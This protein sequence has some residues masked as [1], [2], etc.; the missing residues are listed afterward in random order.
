MKKNRRETDLFPPLATYLE[1][2]G[3]IV[4]A[5][6][7]GTDIA[8]RKDDELLLIEMKLQF[9]LE[10]VLQAVKKQG[11]ADN[12][13]VAIPVSGK[14]RYPPRWSSIRE[15]MSRL[16]IG[17]FFVRFYSSRQ[18]VVEK[19]VAASDPRF[20]GKLRKQK[21][22]QEEIIREIDGRPGNFNV[23]GSTRKKL[24][25]A[26]LVKVIRI[27]DLLKG[28][29]KGLSI[30]ELKELGAPENCGSI[31]RNDFNN[32]FFKPARGIYTLNPEGK[33]SLRSYADIIKLLKNKKTPKSSG[34]LK[35]AI[36]LKNKE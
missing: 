27:A 35:T 36:E 18:P 4:H 2:E 21:K 9:N 19:V 25:T 5:E 29:P 7:K 28:K 8:A 11:A 10:V 32:W 34:L 3:Y 16:G 13:Y 33:K 23:G 31:L 12:T 30:K 22:L 15:L 14:R 17:V 1:S 6:V 20:E 24:V 26:Y